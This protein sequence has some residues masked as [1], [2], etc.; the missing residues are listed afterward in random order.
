MT[1]CSTE[2]GQMKKAGPFNCCC[3]NQSVRSLS[4][5]LCQGSRW[6]FWAH[7]V[8]FSWFSLLS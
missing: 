4:L 1:S 6:T 2:T 8:V 7:Y 3:S 5:R